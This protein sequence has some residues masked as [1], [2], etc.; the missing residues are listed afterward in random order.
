MHTALDLAA[1]AGYLVGKLKVEIQRFLS[2]VV[3]K[4]HAQ[5]SLGSRVI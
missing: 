1:V 5:Q 2:K 4:A 3:M